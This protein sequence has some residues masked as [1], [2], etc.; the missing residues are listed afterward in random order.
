M[1][2]DK[3]NPELLWVAPGSPAGDGS[4]EKPYSTIRKAL[5]RVEPGNTIVLKSGIY[6]DDVTIQKSGTARKPVR[7][8]CDENSTVEVKEACWFLYDVSDFIISGITFSNAPYGGISVIGACQRNRFDS[9]QFIDCGTAEKASC[10][11]FFGGS[12]AECNVVENCLFQRSGDRKNDAT[13]GLMVS[14]GDIDTG[15]PIKNHLFRR[16]RFI[17]YGYGILVGSDDSSKNPYGH[18]VEYNT[19][20]NCTS[21]GIVVKCGDTQ[22]RGNLIHSCMSSPISILSG[23]GSTI[24]D[25]RIVDCATGIQ[26]HGSGH[27]VTNNCIIR[28]G[29]E[30]VRVCGKTNYL[31]TE[32]CNLFIEN[33]T[34]IDCG[35]NTEDLSC[36]AGFRIEPGTTCIIQRNLVSGKGESC[37]IIP[38]AG[39]SDQEQPAPAEYVIRDNLYQGNTEPMNGF[40]RGN[41]EFAESRSDNYENNSGYGAHG[42]MMRSEAFDPHLDESG[43]GEVDY[44]DASVLE[45]ENGELIVP[46]EFNREEL[47]R[48]FFSEAM[49]Q[50]SLQLDDE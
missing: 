20:E 30:A 4:W 31:N 39:G 7:I 6:T 46:G 5:E 29:S 28:C 8:I 43:D 19:V 33:N 49:D 9:I 35:S 21:G 42:W 48:N 37:V 50:E 11:L 38:V 32:A 27:S 16:N 17:N 24:E 23:T 40:F 34:S 15:L 12:G 2:L 18:I 44:L 22:I 3:S 26:V 25:N 36:V 10:T 41:V 13:I 47:F 1:T 14:E 45:D